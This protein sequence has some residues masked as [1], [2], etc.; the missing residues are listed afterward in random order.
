MP[1]SRPGV[2][3]TASLALMIAMAAT[4]AGAALA[5]PVDLPLAPATAATFP[6][7]VTVAKTPTGPVYTDAR[8]RTLYGL[9]LR[10]LVRWGA[11]PAQYCKGGA[12]T[13]SPCSL[14]PEA[15]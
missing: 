1:A 11:D 8:G 4:E 5:Q 2:L 10:T 14:L 13:G 3:R 9:D 6:P 7:G 12:Q 15:L